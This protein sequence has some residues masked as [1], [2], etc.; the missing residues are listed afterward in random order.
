ML[1]T[2]IDEPAIVF[3]H[4]VIETLEYLVVEEGVTFFQ[5]FAAPC[6]VVGII[7]VKPRKNLVLVC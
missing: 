6:M 1:R 7:L 3:A 5:D 4:F 2:F